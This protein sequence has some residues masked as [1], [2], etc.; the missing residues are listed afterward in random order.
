MKAM[1]VNETLKSGWVVLILHP[2]FK[3]PKYL[4][5]YGDYHRGEILKLTS[6]I[7]RSQCFK[8]LQQAQ[9]AAKMLELRF[10]EG[11]IKIIKV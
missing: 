1:T 3:E 11:I 4:K 10:K 6:K 2:S 7:K 9:I 8:Y 5:D